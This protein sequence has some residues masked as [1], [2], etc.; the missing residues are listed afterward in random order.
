MLGAPMGQEVTMGLR[1]YRGGEEEMPCDTYLG[2]QGHRRTVWS[3]RPHLD[4]DLNLGSSLHPS[5][6]LESSLE[7][8]F[9]TYFV[10]WW[11]WG[12]G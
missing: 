2:T 5:A 1:G 11:W 3:L 7:S 9:L 6:R 12:T 10:A 8:L 4:T